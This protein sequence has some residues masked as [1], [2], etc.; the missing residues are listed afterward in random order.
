MYEIYLHHLFRLRTEYW[1]TEST[2]LRNLKL[3]QMVLF[4]NA[5][6]RDLMEFVSEEAPEKSDP[7]A[8]DEPK[9]TEKA[10]TK[11]KA[12][13]NTKKAKPYD[14]PHCDFTTDSPKALS[15]HMKRHSQK[16]QPTPTPD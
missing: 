7:K 2:S 10:G 12:F 3:S 14:C 16:Y 8:E 13:V 5:C 9:A 1:Q 4:A 15:G 11:A 6:G